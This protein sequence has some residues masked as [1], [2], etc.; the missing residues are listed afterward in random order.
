MKMLIWIIWKELRHIIADPMS[1]R[2]IVAP[3][4]VE[5]F[6][7]GYAFTTDVKNVSLAV[8]DESRTAESR[9]LRDAL[10]RNDLFAGVGNHMDRGAAYDCI[11]QGSAKLAIIIPESFHTASRSTI[12]IIVDGQ[13]PNYCRT[14][15]GYSKAIIKRWALQ[16]S[17]AGPENQST[18]NARSVRVTINALFN[19]GLK[20]SWYMIPGLV[21][22]IVSMSAGLLTGFAIMKEKESGTLEQLMVTPIEPVQIII[23]KI[24]PFVVIGTIEILL[25]GRLAGLWFDIPFH[26]SYFPLTVVAVLYLLSIAGI[27]AFAAVTAKNAQ[28]VLFIIWFGNLYFLILSG[29]F[30][31][32]E[33]M[34]GWAQTLAVV[35]PLRSCIIAAREIALKGAQLR[36]LMK[37]CAI[38]A[39][40]GFAFCII[41]IAMFAKKPN[42]I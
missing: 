15:A 18:P 32:T 35:N 25:L 1:I 22:I 31:P 3:A 40:L 2:L 38:M 5:V 41:S 4:V 14:A 11:V 29:W 23:G 8:V 39:A 16:N 26:G 27:G 34:P 6:L 17:A 37:D 30:I 20:S 42:N 10:L 21:I 24:V 13:D 28:Q 9:S 7:L 12:Q 33:N 36:Y 19:P